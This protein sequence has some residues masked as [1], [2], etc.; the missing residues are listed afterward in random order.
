MANLRQG[1]VSIYMA[2]ILKKEEILIK[3][4]PDRYRD[5]IYIDDVINAYMG[6]LENPKSYSKTYNVGTGVKTT[7]KELLDV[8]IKAFGYDINSYPVKFSGSTPGDT[9]GIYADYGAIKNDVGWEPNIF[10]EEG[11]K[12]MAAWALDLREKGNVGK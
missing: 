7:V 5:F 3:G 9:F 2:Y 10:L 6:C 11:V 12:R 8:E 1:M 4:S